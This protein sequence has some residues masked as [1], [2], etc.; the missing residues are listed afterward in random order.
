MDQKSVLH[1]LSQGGDFGELHFNLVTGQYAGDRIQQPRAVAGRY[2]EQPVLGFFVGPQGHAGSDREALDPPRYAALGRKR[3]GSCIGN[4]QCQVGLQHAGQRLVMFFHTGGRDHLKGVER[5]ALPGGVHPGIN[6]AERGLV[7]VAAN[8]GKQIGLVRGVNQH[9]Q[10]LAQRGSACAHYRA[11]GFHVARQ[12]FGVPG[13]IKCVVAHEI[14]H[15][16]RIP[17]RFV[18]FKR[19][20]MQ[21]QVDQGFAFAGLYFGVGVRCPAAEYPHGEAVQVFQ[22]LAFPGVPNLGRGA[23][24]ICHRKQ[25]ERS[26]VALIAH[27]LGKFG[28][29]RAVTKVRLLRNPAHGQ[30]LCDQ[31]LYERRVLRVNAVLFAKAP[32]LYASQL[33]VVAPTPFGN[34]M[35]KRRHIQEPGFVPARGQLRAKRVF[36]RVLHDKKAPYVSQHGQDVLVHRVHMKQVVLHLPDDAPEYPQVAPQHRG[37]VHQAHGVG[38]AAGLHQDA[39]KCGPVDRVAAKGSVHLAAGVVKRPQGSG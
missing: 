26:E 10:S 12:L 14:A 2:V 25:V 15:V 24:Y 38:D 39:H 35:K 33:G 18:G 19:Q 9:L 32:R 16:Q 6:D 20:A 31:E 23:A 36:V 37:L 1:P 34:V 4:R 8:A 11:T 17:Q 29:H 30:M 28:N 7:K 21:R 3:E 22:Q 5:V 27:A 13:N